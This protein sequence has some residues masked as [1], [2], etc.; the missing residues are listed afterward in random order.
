MPLYDSQALFAAIK[1]GDLDTVK[2]AIEAGVDVNESRADMHALM[3]AVREKNVEIAQT[4]IDAGAYVDEPNTFGWTAL[5][6][7]T[8]SGQMPM[9]KMMDE[10][11]LDLRVASSRGDGLIHAA[12]Q[13]NT[14]G[15]VP[16]FAERGVNVDKPNKNQVTPVMMAAEL[17]HENSFAELVA[18]GADL[19][20]L[21]SAQVSARQRAA[22]WPAGLEV[23][24]R[25]ASTPPAV[26]Q[27]V[28]PVVATPTTPSEDSPAPASAPQGIRKRSNGM[29]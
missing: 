3:F 28:A 16:F 14:T 1:R 29:R 11:V 2:A 19:D 22:Q 18:L 5:L 10:Y 25:L 27:E 4:L 6:E 17:G 7:A 13:G 15:M 20:R 24:E 8:R 21:D 12:V 9:V 26:A 23:I